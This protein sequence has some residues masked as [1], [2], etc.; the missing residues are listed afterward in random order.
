MVK[1][2]MGGIF[3][4]TATSLASLAVLVF[5]F[6]PFTASEFIKDLFFSALFLAV[7][8]LATTVLGAAGTVLQYGPGQFIQKI[9]NIESRSFSNALRR[10]GIIA[11]VLVFPLLLGHAGVRLRVSLPVVAFPLAVLEAWRFRKGGNSD[12]AEDFS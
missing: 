6:D 2:H 9:L 1:W 8:G 10:G 5:A 7:W 11:A 12:P 4:I 3:L